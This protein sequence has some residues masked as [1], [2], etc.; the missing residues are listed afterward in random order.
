MAAH[1]NVGVLR[2][3]QQKARRGCSQCNAIASGIQTIE[4][5]DD[6]TQKFTWDKIWYPAGIEIVLLSTVHACPLR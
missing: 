5:K 6:A 1:R 4:G 3:Q 2:L